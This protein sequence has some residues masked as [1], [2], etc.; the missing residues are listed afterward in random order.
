MED[1]LP[2]PFESVSLI[3]FEAEII[4]ETIDFVRS[5]IKQGRRSVIYPMD[6]IDDECIFFTIYPN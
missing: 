6:I 5:S 1:Y 3:P 4:K 2:D